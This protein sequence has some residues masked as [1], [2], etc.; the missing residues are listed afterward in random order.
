MHYKDDEAEP[1]TGG[2]PHE[3]FRAHCYVTL[4]ALLYV[5]SQGCM[6]VFLVILAYN[7]DSTHYTELKTCCT[8]SWTFTFTFLTMAFTFLAAAPWSAAAACKFKSS[9]RFGATREAAWLV[10]VASVLM[11]AFAVESQLILLK[12]NRPST[13]WWVVFAPLYLIASL[14]A[15]FI[16]TA[17]WTFG[18]HE[19]QVRDLT[20][21]A[22]VSLAEVVLMHDKLQNQRRS[23]YFHPLSLEDDS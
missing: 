17:A 2:R 14:I 1:L 12:I 13:S 8:H 16:V 10:L 6:A 20:I 22:I 15:A 4:T 9:A 21:M 11:M 19:R 5:A 7:L 23:T 18:H 3:S